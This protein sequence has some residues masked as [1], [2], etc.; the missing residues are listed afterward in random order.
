MG[1]F[2]KQQS[3]RVDYNY[4]E[5]TLDTEADLA[6][7]PTASCA[8]GSICFIIDGSKVFMLNTEKEW[9]EI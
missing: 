3:S 2:L 9:K 6:E 7:V 1:A 5:Y 8:P 4:R